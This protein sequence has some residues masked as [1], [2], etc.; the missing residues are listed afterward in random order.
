MQYSEQIISSIRPI[1]EKTETIMTAMPV[2]SR[3][4]KKE[5][6]EE[7]ADALNM[8]PN[9][10]APFVLHFMRNAPAICTYRVGKNGG[11]QRIDE[12]AIN[13]LASEVEETVQEETLESEEMTG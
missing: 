9:E 2:G 3:K 5:M 7:V 10:V 1:F 6:F 13:E 8:T 12:N 11:C 4:V